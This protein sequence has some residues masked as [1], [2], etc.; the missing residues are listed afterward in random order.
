MNELYLVHHGV[1]GQ[2]WGVKNGPPYPLTKRHDIKKVSDKYSKELKRVR[3]SENTKGYLYSYKDK[4]VSMI[5]VE[6]KENGEKWIQGLEVF[7]DNKGKGHG[8]KMLDVAVNDLGATYLSVRKTNTAAKN[9][10]D[11]NN[12]KTYKED[13]YM[14]YMKYKK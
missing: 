12:W 13:D 2:K 5:N 6:T 7:G 14:Y 4:P 10:Y 3:M 11:K 8:Q 1:K 9:L